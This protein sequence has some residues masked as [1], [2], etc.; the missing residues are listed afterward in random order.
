MGSLRKKLSILIGDRNT[1]ILHIQTLGLEQ[2]EGT[3]HGYV[4][5]ELGNG[6]LAGIGSRGKIKF[7]Q[8]DRGS[9]P[10]IEA[11]VVQQVGND[12]GHGLIFGIVKIAGDHKGRILFGR[13]FHLKFKG[14]IRIGTRE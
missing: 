3:A 14:K 4:S 10:G 6:T 9:D 1:E 2:T 5:R 11:A 7:F 8:G 12:G 13:H